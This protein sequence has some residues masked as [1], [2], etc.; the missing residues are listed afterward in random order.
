MLATIALP[1]RSESEATPAVHL[2]THVIRVL[3]VARDVTKMAEH[4]VGT[5]CCHVGERIKRATLSISFQRKD[6]NFNEHLWK[7]TRLKYRN[8]FKEMKRYCKRNKHVFSNNFIC[9]KLN[10]ETRWHVTSDQA[11]SCA[12][13][14]VKCEV[15]LF[16]AEKNIKEKILSEVFGVVLRNILKINIKILS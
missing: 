2:V 9:V 16:Y 7:I 8:V 11:T 15:I 5:L 4:A 14:A 6:Y 3:A 13:H 1:A 10:Q 12:V